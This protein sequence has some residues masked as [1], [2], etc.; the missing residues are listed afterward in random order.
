M[1]ITPEMIKAFN[2][3]DDDRL[4]S[5]LRLKPWEV[6]PLEAV[7]ECPYPPGTCG[8]LSWPQARALRNELE[9][10]RTSKRVSNG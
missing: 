5:L 3:D 9:N 6:S 10:C 2:D 1:R 8:A 7:G 4:I